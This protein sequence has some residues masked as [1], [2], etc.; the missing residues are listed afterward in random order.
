MNICHGEN[1]NNK[2]YTVGTNKRAERKYRLYAFVGYCGATYCL[3]CAKRMNIITD[4]E[5]WGKIHDSTGTVEG[6][7][8]RTEG[9]T[10]ETYI[11]PS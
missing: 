6:V 7:Q 10:E 3:K 9:L 1:C 5:I 8:E 11:N 4:D 2:P